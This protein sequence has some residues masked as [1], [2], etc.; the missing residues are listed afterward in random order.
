MRVIEAMLLFPCRKT[1]I[2]IVLS[3]LLLVAD[4]PS[5]QDSTV[6]RIPSHVI[7][8]AQRVSKAPVVD[9]VLDEEI[10]QSATS[11]TSF[12]QA[13][14]LEGQPASELT[15]VRVLYDELSIFVGAILYDADP[16]Q[17]VTSETRRDSNL[18]DQD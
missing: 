8:T 1:A 14:P 7:A 2:L 17:I 4:S 3:I 5:A 10:W 12:V 16:S 15:E 11:L 6:G 18:G 9:G 13:E